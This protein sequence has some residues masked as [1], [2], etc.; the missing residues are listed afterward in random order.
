MLMHPYTP[1]YMALQAGKDSIKGKASLHKGLPQSQIH[2]RCQLSVTVD[3]ATFPSHLKL[4]PSRL[5]K[6]AC[7]E[8][9]LLS[10]RMATF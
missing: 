4:E 9:P 6:A 8:T 10:F 2:K 5:V 3:H 7:D 1:L